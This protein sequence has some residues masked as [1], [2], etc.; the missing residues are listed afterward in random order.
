MFGLFS[1]VSDMINGI[2]SQVLQQ[3]NI[4]LDAVTSPLR[5]MVNSVMAGVWKGDGATRFV[6]EMT[7][8]VI[9]MLVGIMSTNTNYANAIRKSH[10]RMNQAFQQA[11]SQAQSLFDVFSSIF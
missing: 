10:D 8:E 7:S 6:S 11:A 2:V 4:I 3:A 5:A 1:F 9:P